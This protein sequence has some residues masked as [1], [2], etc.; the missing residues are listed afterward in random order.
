M[1]RAV[2]TCTIYAF[3]SVGA[4]ETRIIGKWLWLWQNYAFKHIAVIRHGLGFRRCTGIYRLFFLANIIETNQFDRTEYPVIFRTGIAFIDAFNADI[5][6]ALKVI[7]AQV[8]FV[9]A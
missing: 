5:V 8:A 2:I 7:F 3:L 9:V 1:P 4:F 6:M